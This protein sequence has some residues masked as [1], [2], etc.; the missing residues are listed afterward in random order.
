MQ[1]TIIFQLCKKE[2]KPILYED[3]VKD[4]G[5]FYEYRGFDFHEECFDEGVKKVDSKRKEVQE[6]IE[7]SVKSQAGG[8][9]MNGGYKTMKTDKSGS[10]IPSKVTEPQILKDYESGK[11]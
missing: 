9:W 1:E 5:D 10:P 4:Y 7:H 6:V 8:E 2:I 3:G 11:L